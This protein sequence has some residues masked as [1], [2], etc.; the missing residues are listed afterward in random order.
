MVGGGRETK[1]EEKERRGEE[2]EKNIGLLD[3]PSRRFND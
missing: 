1:G 3:D 2:K